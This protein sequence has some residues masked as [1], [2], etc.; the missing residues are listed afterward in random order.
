MQFDAGLN[1]ELRFL[2]VA[3]VEIGS[4]IAPRVTVP[5]TLRGAHLVVRRT[6]EAAESAQ[7]DQYG[8]ISPEPRAGIVHVLVSKAQLHRALLILQGIFAACEAAG[9]SI[10]EFNGG[11]HAHSASPGAGVQVEEFVYPVEIR[12][13]TRPVPLTD[14]ELEV[15]K[16]SFSWSWNQSTEKTVPSGEL[17]LMFPRGPERGARWKWANGK[18]EKLESKLI[19]VIPE[20]RRRVQIDREQKRKRDER[21][22]E[23]AAEAERRRQRDAQQRI[24]NGRLERAEA[25]AVLWARSESLRAFAAEL[26]LRLKNHES[27]RH[28]DL[29]GWADLIERKAATLDPLNEIDRLRTFD[30]ELD[31]YWVDQSRI[32][33][34]R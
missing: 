5:E 29:N 27:E 2:Y 20:L 17:E 33:R 12:E 16:K 26:R 24:E 8:R 25:Q 30:D 18:T 9:L 31:Q 7:I 10:E 11:Y 6:R 15:E 1:S 23:E 14:A 22:A 28:E 32:N 13:T 3:Q 21:V 19:T 4:Q 34:F